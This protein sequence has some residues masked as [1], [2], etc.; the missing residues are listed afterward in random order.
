MEFFLYVVNPMFFPPF[1]ALLGLV[2][3]SSFGFAVLAAVAVGLILLI[4]STRSM[5]FTYLS[6]NVT[7]LAAFFQELKGNKQ[8]TWTKIDDTRSETVHVTC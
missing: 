6:N 5:F 3:V 2:I 8:L 1:I 7:M 4:R